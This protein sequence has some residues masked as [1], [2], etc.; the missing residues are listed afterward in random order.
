V[1]TEEPNWFDGLFDKKPEEVK[2]LYVEPE[3]EPPSNPVKEDAVSKE[4]PPGFF[5]SLFRKAKNVQEA[6]TK[7]AVNGD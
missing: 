5:L 3:R 2:S 7:P 4:D 6:A 1:K